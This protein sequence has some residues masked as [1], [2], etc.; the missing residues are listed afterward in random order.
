MITAKRS[1]HRLPAALQGER[2]AVFEAQPVEEQ[3]AENAERRVLRQSHGV[4]LRGERHRRRGCGSL[5]RRAMGARCAICGAKKRLT[6]CLAPSYNIS[7][8]CRFGTAA[9]SICCFYETEPSVIKD[10]AVLFFISASCFSAEGRFE[11]QSYGDRCV[12]SDFMRFFRS[13]LRNEGL[14]EF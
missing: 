2:L 13:L 1:V 3:P 4:S 10:L 14:L 8:S 7:K 5:R 12:E 9:C 11:W 6:L